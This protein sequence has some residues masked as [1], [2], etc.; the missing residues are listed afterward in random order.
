MGS[1]SSGSAGDSG[2]RAKPTAPAKRSDRS[3]LRCLSHRSSMQPTGPNAPR[4]LEPI[5]LNR[6][7]VPAC[8]HEIRLAESVNE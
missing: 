4:A 8:E 3:R 5:T 7:R 1:P 6:V 2:G